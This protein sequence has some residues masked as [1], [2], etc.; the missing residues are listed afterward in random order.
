[1]PSYVTEVNEIALNCLCLKLNLPELAELNCTVSS[2]EN[3]A[4]KSTHIYYSQA[5]TQEC[6][7]H[8][9]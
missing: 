6:V 4:H 8:I 2:T 9:L 7:L 5:M 1:M 3:N